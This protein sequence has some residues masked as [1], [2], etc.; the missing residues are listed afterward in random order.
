M[1]ASVKG[2]DCVKF[3]QPLPEELTCSICMKVLCEPHLVNCC[4]QQYCKGC[5]DEWQKKNKTCPHCRSDDFAS[6]LMKQTKRKIGELK[7]YCPNKRHGCKAEIKI[8]EHASHLSTTN[9]E[10]CSY[11]ELDCPN[12][13]RT[14]VFR[15]AIETHTQKK[16]PKRVVCCKLCK[17]EGEYQAIAGEHVNKCPSYPL[18]CPLGCGAE[19]I[20]K[21][22]E[23]HRSTCPLEPVLCPFSECGCKTKVCRKDLDKH[24]ETSTLQH[25]TVLAESHRALQNKLMAVASV[26]SDHQ[27]AQIYT[28]LKDCST[29]TPGRPL[30]FGMSDKPGNHHI[31][32]SQE[33]PKPDHKFKLEWEPV[34]DESPASDAS[35]PSI[36][37]H[38]VHH[39]VRR[40]KSVL[41]NFKLHFISEA[42]MTAETEFDI[43]FN[44]SYIVKVCC[45]K[46][47]GE[48]P[49]KDDSPQPMKTFA[50]QISPVQDKNSQVTIK[51]NPHNSRNCTCPCHP[52]PPPLHSC[53]SCGSQCIKTGVI[54]TCQYCYQVHK[55]P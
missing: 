17:L 11:V 33:P 4:E 3:V 8:S 22:L 55:C 52:Q 43:S 54:T 44:G 48:P 9:T 10:G 18:P 14:R 49:Q 6:I 31:I 36:R 38:V 30:T 35:L 16:C 1:G 46:L 29:L 37:H 41:I 24:I 20:R 26:L 34:S 40:K 15:G 25:M 5:L 39:V 12:D 7:V 13:C 50:L 23:S 19:L 28:T 32:L 53:P 21:D 45:G 47:Q 42:K 2:I 51:F 27:I